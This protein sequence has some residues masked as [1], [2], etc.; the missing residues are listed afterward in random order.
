M[1]SLKAGTETSVRGS[2]KSSNPG[3]GVEAVKAAR[4]KLQGLARDSID[5]RLLNAL[6]TYAPTEESVGVIA[7]D[8]LAASTQP[9]GFK[10]LAEFYTKG[11]LLPSKLLITSHLVLNIYLVDSESRWEDATGFVSSFAR[12]G[13]QDRGRRHCRRSRS[14]QEGSSEVEEICKSQLASAP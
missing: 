5:F 1:M 3:I 11:L 10:Q 13:C 4:Q 8:I 9:D 14:R 2:K 12:R 7:G 6:L